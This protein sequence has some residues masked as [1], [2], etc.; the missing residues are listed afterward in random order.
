VATTIGGGGRLTDPDDAVPLL[1]Q[2]E[3]YANFELGQLSIGVVTGVIARSRMQTF[4]RVLWRSL[5]GNLY[6]NASEIDEAIGT[7]VDEEDAVDKNVFAVFAHGREIVNKIRK[8]SESMGATL[9]DIDPSEEAR[10]DALLDVTG[11]IE[12]LN[13][14][15][16]NGMA[17]QK[18]WLPDH[19]VFT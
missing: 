17:S 2:D 16:I 5:R 10:R 9:Y 7:G 3:E 8:I 12:D 15:S 11:R 4:E 6:M 14:V 1:E 13:N 19:V 18:G